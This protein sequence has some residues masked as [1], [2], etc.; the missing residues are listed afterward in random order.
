[1]VSLLAVAQWPLQSM[2]S[3]IGVGQSSYL[4]FLNSIPEEY[5]QKVKIIIGVLASAIIA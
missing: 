4:L 2:K 5:E 1:M 3:S